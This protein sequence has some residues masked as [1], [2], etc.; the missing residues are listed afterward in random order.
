MNKRMILMI[1]SL[2]VGVLLL[3]AV[4]V[5]LAGTGLR[6][7]KGFEIDRLERRVQ[8]LEQRISALEGPPR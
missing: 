7:V 4:S 3:S 8:A 1:A 5:W 2:V 6:Q